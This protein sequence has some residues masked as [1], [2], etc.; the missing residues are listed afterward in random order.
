MTTLNGTKGDPHSYDALDTLLEAQSYRLSFWRVA[1]EEINYRRFFAINELAAIRQELPEVFAATHSLIL[2]LIGEAKI[3]GLRIDHPDGLL[4]P[5][6]YYRHLQRATFLTRCRARFDQDADGQ[7]WDEI[8]PTL[9]DAWETRPDDHAF[10][11]VVEKILEPGEELPLS[12]QVAGTVGYEFARSTTGLLIDPAN[13]KAFSTIY[14]RFTGDLPNFHDL[15][16]EKKQ[17]MMDVALASEVNVLAEAINRI[18]EQD[19][20]TRDFT[21]NS[22]RFA[23]REIIASFPIYRTYVTCDHDIAISPADQRYIDRAV[24]L[25]KRRN[26]GSNTLVLDFVRDVLLL[27]GLDELT[28]DQRDERCRFSMKFQQLTGPVMAKG[29]EDTAL[30]IDNRLAALNEVGGDPTTFG[31][32][33]EEFHKQSLE[34]HKRWPHTLLSSSTHDTKRSEDVRARMAVLSEIPREWRANLNRWKRLNRKHK[35]RIEGTVAPSANDE[36]LLYQTLLGTWPVGEDHPGDEFT[37]RIIAYMLKA[38]REAQVETTWVNQNS[39]YEDALTGFIRALLNPNNTLFFDD[40]AP[41]RQRV[42]E[43]G[44]VNSF[45]QQVLK[46][47]APGVPDIYQGTEC[48][49]FSLVDPDNRRAVDYDDRRALLDTIIQQGP[50]N[51]LTHGDELKLHVTHRA[52]NL[53]RTHP[54]LL[55]DGE[56]VPLSATGAHQTNVIAFARRHGDEEVLIVVPRLSLALTKS[57]ETM[58]IGDLWGETRVQLGDRA[59][60]PRYL[61]LFTGATAEARDGHL[62]C[63]ELFSTLPVAMLLNQLADEHA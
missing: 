34:R 52:L 1:A 6:G 58:P 51:T 24:S 43:V 60:M 4:D 55:L 33:P 62:R 63:A 20:H 47:T 16:Y 17:L 5:A 13:R 41:L 54:H 32:L 15:V 14:E 29:M 61:N 48:W 26:P 44:I 36:Y 45:A 39:E 7:E 21:L 23:V 27:R 30:Y 57:E 25:A 56:Y 46:L 19:R 11:V 3:T 10:Y 22:L 38:A 28:P 2:R 53:R 42:A 9:I 8:E 31:I 59:T 49:D 12:W 50:E 40:F 35:R 37:E 18:S